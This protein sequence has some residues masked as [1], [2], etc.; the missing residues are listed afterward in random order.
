MTRMGHGIVEVTICG[1]RG[2]LLDRRQQPLTV[3][4]DSNFLIKWFAG[5]K[6]PLGPHA[7]EIGC[8]LEDFAVSRGD[9]TLVEDAKTTLLRGSRMMR[10][11]QTAGGRWYERQTS[12]HHEGILVTYSDIESR[13]GTAAAMKRLT[14]ELERRVDARTRNLRL[15]HETLVKEAETK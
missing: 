5:S 1:H 10:E 11:V 7:S 15:L 3:C 14:V 4:A 2:D 9:S 12:I 6:G 8:S 13:K